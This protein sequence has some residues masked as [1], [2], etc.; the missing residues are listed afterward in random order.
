M[1]YKF[2]PSALFIHIVRDPRAVVN[3]WRKVPWSSGN[4]IYDT[5]VWHRNM[6][7]IDNLL[8]HIK[9]SIMTINYEKLVLYPEQ[10]LKKICNFIGV[11]FEAQM[12]EFHTINNNLVNV[13]REPWK[14]NIRQPLNPKLINQWQSELSPS[15]IF[16][17]EAVPWF[18]M[19]RLRYPLNTPL[20]KLLPKSLKIYFSENKKNQINQQIKSLLR[21]K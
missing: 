17:I 21:I 1:I 13:D 16:D 11:E 9:Y 5:R 19:I 4:V 2:F 6:I 14:I 3:S 7:L 12:L 10:T 18:Q 15:M 8:T 20:F